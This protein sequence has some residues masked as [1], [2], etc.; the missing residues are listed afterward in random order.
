VAA[1]KL[2]GPRRHQLRLSGEKVSFISL[3]LD[4]VLAVPL[5][6][7]GGTDTVQTFVSCRWQQG[8]IDAVQIL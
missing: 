6:I 2:R 1:I 7:S 5:P 8:G 3:P 4:V